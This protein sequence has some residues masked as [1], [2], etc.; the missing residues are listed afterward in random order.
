MFHSNVLVTETQLHGYRK[1]K[2]CIVRKIE[3]TRIGTGNK[4]NL[5][6]RVLQ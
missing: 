2:W 6:C 3:N 5:T 1:K 4:R